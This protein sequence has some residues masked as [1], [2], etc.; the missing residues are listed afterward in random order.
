MQP[1][2]N[3]QK[4]LESSSLS[5]TSTTI[6]SPPAWTWFGHKGLQALCMQDNVVTVSKFP[7][8]LLLG[9]GLWRMMLIIWQRYNIFNPLLIIRKRKHI[10]IHFFSWRQVPMLLPSTSA[11]TGDCYYCKDKEVAPCWLQ[12][13]QNPVTWHSSCS[14]AIYVQGETFK[15]YCSILNE[16]LKNDSWT[17]Q[18]I[19][20]T[21]CS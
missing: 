5:P 8:P 12:N 20:T 2:T 3:V 6:R 11:M 19:R 21:C 15:K 1:E 14:V 16:Q 10:R 17:H 9:L 4:P 13:K 7:L 18:K